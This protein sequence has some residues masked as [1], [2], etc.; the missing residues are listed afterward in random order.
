MGARST[1][2]RCPA[3]LVVEIVSWLQTQN[4]CIMLFDGDHVYC[5]C[6]P[7]EVVPDFHVYAQGDHSTYASDLRPMIPE[8]TEIILNTSLDREQL[9]AVYARAQQRW[10]G[11]TRVLFSHPFGVDIMPHSSKSAGL[12]VVGSTLGDRPRAGPGYR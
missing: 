10:G 8:Q 3:P 4:V 11:M 2:R 6:T 1:A 12:V 7:E 5:D 9:A